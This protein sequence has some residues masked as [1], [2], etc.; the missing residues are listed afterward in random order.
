[1]LGDAPLKSPIYPIANKLVGPQKHNTV[2]CVT[3]RVVEGDGRADKRREQL[4]RLNGMIDEVGLRV[5]V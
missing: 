4:K 2:A 3:T 1:M 5:W